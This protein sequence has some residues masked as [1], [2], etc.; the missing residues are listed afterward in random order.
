MQ[1]MA[2][3]PD[4]MKPELDRESEAETYSQGEIV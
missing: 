2:F 4:N 1:G 3:I